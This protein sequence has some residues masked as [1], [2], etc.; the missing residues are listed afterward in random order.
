MPAV[1]ETAG[2]LRSTSYGTST[3]V[4]LIWSAFSCWSARLA[5]SIVMAVAGILGTLSAR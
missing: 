4:P 1:V 5:S 2:S 3:A